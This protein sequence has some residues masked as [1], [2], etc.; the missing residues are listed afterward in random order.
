VIKIKIEES[1]DEQWNQRLLN[2]VT[3]SIYQTK[4]YSEFIQHKG[5]SPR[6]LKF[7][8]NDE[9]IVG[10]IL[11]STYSRFQKKKG[12]KFL[13]FVPIIKKSIYR[14]VFGPVIFDLSKSTEIHVSLSQFLNSQNCKVSGS[15]HPLIPNSFQ[16][17]NSS[18]HLENWGT[19]LIDLKTS[20]DLLFKKFDKHSARKNIERSQKRGVVITEINENNLFEYYE[21]LKETKSKVDWNVTFDEILFLWKKLKPIGFTGFLATHEEIPVGGILISYF[22][23]YINEWGV[24]RSKLDYSK[25][26]YSQDL[27]KWHIINWGIQNNHNFYDL[28]GANPNPSS[29]KESGILRYKKKWAGKYVEYN[30]CKI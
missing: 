17:M 7:I 13:N 25:K 9:N 20:S 16:P 26:L 21:L 19:F 8:D 15:E 5:W 11:L 2:S 14:W 3:G 28:T 12:F 24:G 30:I 23:N 29:E 18:F 10:Q 1:F 27:L 4:E 6:F 22:N